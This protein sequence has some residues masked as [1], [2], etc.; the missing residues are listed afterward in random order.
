MLQ[1]GDAVGLQK[2]RRGGTAGPLVGRSL[3]ALRAAVSLSSHFWWH[4]PR[5]ERA[6]AFARLAAVIAVMVTR[7]RASAWLS[8]ERRQQMDTMLKSSGRRAILVGLARYFGTLVVLSPVNKLYWR[9][10]RAL[11]QQ[12]DRHLTRHFLSNFVE[13]QCLSYGTLSDGQGKH[14]GLEALAEEARL[15]DQRI[16]TDVGVF[17]QLATSLS[18]ESLQAL[19]HLYFFAG[20]LRDISPILSRSAMFAA[21]VGTLATRF[22]GRRLPMLYAAER[23]A[24]GDF[25]YGLTRMRENAESIAFYG[26]QRVEELRMKDKLDR[27]LGSEWAR[28]AR[29]DLVQW[30]S[31]TYR[32]VV[33]LL[34][35]YVLAGRAAS[36]FSADHGGGGH[37]HGH[38][39][40]HA[41]G[42]GGSTDLGAVTQ[43]REAFDEVL[44]HLLILA[45]NTSDFSRL[46][47]VALEL[48]AYDCRSRYVV[49]QLKDTGTA[50]RI[51]LR[52]TAAAADE[53]AAAPGTVQPWLCIEGLSLWAPSSP[54][55]LL[56]DNLSLDLRAGGLLVCGPSGVGKTTLLRA[57]AGIWLYGSGT[58][59]RE[60][61]PRKVL[62]LPQQPYM[63]DG[64]L[65]EQVLYPFGEVQDAPI[66]DECIRAA[67]SRVG[68]GH[69]LQRV[70]GDLAAYRRWA[71]ELSVGELQRLSVARI[72]VHRPSF[73][74]LDETT[75]ANDLAHEEVMYKC[76]QETCAA[77]VSVGHRKSIECFHRR[78]L[79]LLGEEQHGHWLLEDM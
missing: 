10:L 29:R 54:P 19:I 1:K 32:Q 67:L 49:A 57:L 59:T 37:A 60:M 71:E 62:F 25:V 63:Q 31:Q 50:S 73:V 30:F 68:L 36:S 52:P 75:A 33:G 74:I 79:V 48:N 65:R 61:D 28:M 51:S 12:W 21:F 64:T 55:R 39:H 45:E 53:A 26:G 42:G 24:D 58:V 27:R 47:T 46:A 20:V 18:L 22:L 11:R 5:D 38:G 16:A 23:N 56:L 69:V 13:A 4:A 8:T 3:P 43:A 66:S 7:G 34:P 15:P 72:L 70:L 77:F 9:L 76:V 78:R 6:A 41:H 14:S 17:V 35:A 40:G 2:E 44:H